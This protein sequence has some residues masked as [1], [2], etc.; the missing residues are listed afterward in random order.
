MVVEPSTTRQERIGMRRLVI[1]NTGKGEPAGYYYGTIVY[2]KTGLPWSG[3]VFG[4]GPMSVTKHDFQNCA[5]RLDSKAKCFDEQ[6]LNT[7]LVPAMFSCMRFIYNVRSISSGDDDT[8]NVMP[9]ARPSNVMF[10]EP[11]VS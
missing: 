4:E 6:T 2:S 7:W 5:I 9:V 3:K 1:Q 10:E 11:Y 8:S